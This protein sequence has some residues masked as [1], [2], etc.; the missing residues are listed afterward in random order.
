MKMQLPK[1]PETRTKVDFLIERANILAKKPARK[2][3]L[4][5]RKSKLFEIRE[6]LTQISTNTKNDHF[7]GQRWD[8][9][10]ITYP[11]G[12]FGQS[13]RLNLS[14]RKNMTPIPP[15]VFHLVQAFCT[16][17]GFVNSTTK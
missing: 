15:L 2:I 16:A 10:H 12:K 4:K 8:N 3:G 13:I 1:Q 5:I 9:L 6:T 11:P 7:L 14:A 17:K